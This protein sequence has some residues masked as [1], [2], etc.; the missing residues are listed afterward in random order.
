MD[1]ENHNIS[2]EQY[3]Q[4]LM[5][6]NSSGLNSKIAKYQYMAVYM[7]QLNLTSMVKNVV[8]EDSYVDVVYVLYVAPDLY[9]IFL[10]FKQKNEYIC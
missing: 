2:N 7:L 9:L 6:G 5:W 4:H 10:F 1:N 3:K 8:M